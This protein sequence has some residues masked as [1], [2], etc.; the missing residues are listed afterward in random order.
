MNATIVTLAA[1]ETLWT[2]TLIRAHSV[3]VPATALAF[4]II[5]LC[6]QSLE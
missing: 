4:Y 1:L 2:P 6:S 5:L 3:S